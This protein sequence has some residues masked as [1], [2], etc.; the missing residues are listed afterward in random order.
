[1]PQMIEIE[2]PDGS[3][4]EFPQGTDDT[5]I[6][7]VMQRSFAPKREPSFGEQMLNTVSD[8]ASG[9]VDY[10]QDAWTGGD[11]RDPAITELP[12]QYTGQFKE[13]EGMLGAKLSL[14]RG[15][16]G[17]LDI[18][19]RFHPD[20]PAEID[21]HGNVIVELDGNKHYLNAPGFSSQ[22][23]S[24]IG[25]TALIEL[26]FASAGGRLLKGAGMLGRA[27]GTGLG[28]GSGS[29]VQDLAA[30]AA[31]SE[32]SIDMQNAAI[33]T[34]GGGA[35]EFAAPLLK[36]FFRKFLGSTKMANNGTLTDAG[37]KTLDRMGIDA[38]E[39]TPEFA[40]RF[41]DMARDAVSPDDMANAAR[42]AQAGEL[43]IPLS[44]GDA[45]GHVMQ[46]GRE[47]SMIKGA[48]GEPASNV[49]RG[50]R[51]NQSDAVMNARNN[52]QTDIG[53]L[54]ID[55]F[56]GVGATQSALRE[57]ADAAKAQ[58]R[59]AY[60]EST[61]KKAGVLKDGVKGMATSIRRGFQDFNPATA[62]KAASLVKQL[63]TFEKKFP[64]NIKSVSVKAIEQFRQQVSALTRSSDPVE[65]A[66]AANIRKSLDNY[67]NDLVNDA[68]MTGDVT[69]IEAFKHARSLRT[70]FAKK[71]EGDKILEKLIDQADGTFLLEPSEATKY[72]FGASKLGS[73][74][75]TTKAIRRIKK[76]L[77]PEHP[78]WMGL[79]EEAFLK[80]FPTDKAAIAK[81]PGAFKKVMAESPELM[82]ELF[83]L[84]DRRKLERFAAVVSNA[85]ARA[86]GA[87]NHSATASTLSRLAQDVFGSSRNIGSF[88]ANLPFVKDIAQ[89]G[90]N[91]VNA[92]KAQAATRPRIPPSVVPPGIAGGIGA[93][94]AQ[95]Y[96]SPE[97]QRAKELAQVLRG[98][99][100]ASGKRNPLAAALMR[101]DY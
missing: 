88:I 31:G 95:E 94:G 3:V 37:R 48:M 17:K 14:S 12:E 97:D 6:K 63:E 71:F 45:S 47:D 66:A 50:F 64:G 26:P 22:D 2:G 52:V 33:A 23:V 25:T 78:A 74:V 67:M 21:E 101:G 20:A 82:N 39:I 56:E 15:D 7:A 86:P 58:V 73:K 85:T 29:V 27:L 49:M 40:R 9:A 90:R 98:K 84:Q 32:Q 100:V 16:I 46:Q 93:V 38:D 30:Q 61:Q 42:H 35:F 65:K 62:P 69:A 44:Q 81:F 83:T 92:G 96:M 79:R 99:N 77:G 55:S 75:G 13:G 57:N 18:F 68:M 19:K 5:T 76:I 54:G 24:D 87:V 36:P 8:A 59:N 28:A 91:A 80:L 72:L 10:V 60:Q 53:G 11:R 89:A 34:L 1:M 51:E 70:E 43:G 4:I 41:E